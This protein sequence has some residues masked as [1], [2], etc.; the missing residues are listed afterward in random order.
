MWALWKPEKLRKGTTN[1]YD[2]AMMY[3]FSA[4]PKKKVDALLA[5]NNIASIKQSLSKWIRQNILQWHEP[6]VNLSKVVKSFSRCHVKTAIPVVV[7]FVGIYPFW[8]TRSETGPRRYQRTKNL[9]SMA[10]LRLPSRRNPELVARWCLLLFPLN[11]SFF[12][13]Y[14]NEQILIALSKMFSTGF[15]PCSILHTYGKRYWTE[16][17]LPHNFTTSR[18]MKEMNTNTG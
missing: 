16:R 9:L 1:P 10:Q 12:L 7:V 3:C 14:D 15:A 2:D 4:L 5:L 6:G 8:C 18:K 17:K 13:S 11:H